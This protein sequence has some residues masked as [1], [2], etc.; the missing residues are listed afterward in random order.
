[1]DA[2]DP[3]Q[4]RPLAGVDPDGDPPAGLEQPGQA[5]EGEPGVGRVVEHAEGIDLV[6]RPRREG[7][8]EEV[9]LDDGDGRILGR[10]VPRRLDRP[11]QVEADDPGPP[12]GGDAEVSAHPAAGV[13]DQR[14]G[15]V[16]RRQAGP[17]GERRPV[18]LGPDDPEPIPLEAI[19]RLGPALVGRG[20]A[21]RGVLA[22]HWSS[23]ALRRR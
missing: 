6:E 21:H 12:F 10:E 22:S 11:A 4:S 15:Q 2:D 13:E 17:V 3:L 19:G 7:E 16:A 23:A 5:E 20:R 1:M 9:A 14:A 18:L 8:A